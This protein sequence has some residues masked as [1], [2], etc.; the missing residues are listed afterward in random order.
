[1][2][3]RS[4]FPL[5]AAI[6]QRVHQEVD[7]RGLVRR[8]EA[9]GL[10]ALGQLGVLDITTAVVVVYHVGQR[11]L[12]AVVH[13]RSRQLLV[14][15]RRRLESATVIAAHR[16][17]DAIWTE[18]RPA[19]ILS[20]RGHTG[21]VEALVATVLVDEAVLGGEVH[22]RVGQLGAGVALAAVT[23]TTKDARA[24]LLA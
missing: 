4:L 12:A 15:E 19:K 16:E 1:M 7:E 2:I 24:L 23:L 18:A 14:A 3:E 17:R 8:A 13:V 22:R 11:C 20:R 6:G 10:D 9:E 21:V 5:G